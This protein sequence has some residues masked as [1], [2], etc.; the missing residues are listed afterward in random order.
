MK[1]NMF[2]VVLIGASEVGKTEI[3]RRITD[4]KFV[5]VYDPTKIIELG[6]KKIFDA[7]FRIIKASSEKKLI[8]NSLK[9]AHAVILVFDI[10]NQ[11]SF[12][13]LPAYLDAARQS[14]PDEF[15]KNFILL[16]NKTDLKSKN[17]VKLEEI[18][19]FAKSEQLK[20]FTV[21][22]KESKNFDHIVDAIHTMCA[23]PLDPKLAPRLEENREL[24]SDSSFLIDF[25]SQ[26][27]V[28]LQNSE[29]E[30]A[31][32]LFKS[33]RQSNDSTTDYFESPL[34]MN[35][36]VNF[37]D[38]TDSNDPNIT[39]DSICNEDYAEILQSTP[40]SDEE[41]LNPSRN[42]FPEESVKT[43]PVVNTSLD[44]D[45]ESEHNHS[46]LTKKISTL[47]QRFPNNTHIDAICGILREG[48]NKDSNQRQEFFN[49]QLGALDSH[50]K[51]LRWMSQSMLNTVVNLMATVFLVLS[52]VGLPLAYCSGYLTSNHQANAGCSLMFF[53]WGEYQSSMELCAAN[54]I[55]LSG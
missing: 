43:A 39:D 31:N 38:I 55:A 10:T 18:L 32:G 4:Q 3:M 36:S 9:T 12:D 23:K 27:L 47:Q 51:A 11:Q 7:I 22:A 44:V 1:P 45:S 13:D 8:A 46:V 29:Q 34:A 25:V 52:I 28:S 19:K 26:Q 40:G 21:S 15:S 17:G 20:F 49:Q 5:G 2:K 35:D 41:E 6:T 54:G 42:L 30:H 24:G 14:V 48:I 50:V 37:I 16:A 53:K 33:D